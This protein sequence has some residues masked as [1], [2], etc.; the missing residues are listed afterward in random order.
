LRIW[1]LTLLNAATTESHAALLAA[2]DQAAEAGGMR[3]YA[4][5]G[6]PFARHTAS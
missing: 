1:R 5:I 3:T 2:A 6:Y 4:G